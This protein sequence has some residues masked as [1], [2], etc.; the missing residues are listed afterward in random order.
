MNTKQLHLVTF[1]QAKRLKEVGFDWKLTD[2]FNSDGHFF[3]TLLIKVLL[4]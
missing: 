2:A 3:K 4:F 1:E